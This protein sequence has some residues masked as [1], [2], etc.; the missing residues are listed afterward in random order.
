MKRFRSDYGVYVCEH[1][2][3]HEKPVSLVIRD[4]DGYWQFLCGNEDD[5]D[6]DCH[7]VGVGHLLDKDPSLAEMTELKIGAGA[8]RPTIN[9]AWC[10]FELDED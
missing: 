2:F 3:R 6:R 5:T 9:D 1:V 7:L 10:F 4:P 8:E